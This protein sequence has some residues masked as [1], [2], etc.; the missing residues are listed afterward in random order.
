MMNP[1]EHYLI[2][3]LTSIASGQTVGRFSMGGHYARLM[4]RLYAAPALHVEFSANEQFRK[5][6]EKFQSRGDSLEFCK[7]L[8]ALLDR[9]SRDLCGMAVSKRAA[10]GLFAM[11][12]PDVRD[13]ATGG[14]IID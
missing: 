13:Y 11:F 10:L 14:S 9:A 6:L 8:W 7:T 5:N 12:D 3:N 4:L 1:E 2:A